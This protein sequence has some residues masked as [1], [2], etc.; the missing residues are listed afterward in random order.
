MTIERLPVIELR[1]LG[2]EV[3]G[4]A[5]TYGQL[6]LRR[7]IW[8]PGSCADTIAEWRARGVWPRLRWRHGMYGIGHITEMREDERGPRVTGRLWRGLELPDMGDA[9]AALRSG[10]RLGMSCSVIVERHERIDG[11]RHILRARIVDDVTITPRPENPH[12][13]VRL[14]GGAEPDSWNCLRNVAR[15]L[16]GLGLR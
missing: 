9:L 6:T 12:T 7:D 10:V 14:A 8:R 5:A 4:Y 2:D 3:W 13:T 1:D 15:E 11:V 16:K